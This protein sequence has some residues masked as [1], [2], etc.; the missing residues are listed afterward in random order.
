[1][2]EV[3]P[4][5]W[6]VKVRKELGTGVGAGSEEEAGGKDELNPFIHPTGWATRGSVHPG[7]EIMS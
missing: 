2:A 4:L 6:S 1:M 7:R 5:S 3:F